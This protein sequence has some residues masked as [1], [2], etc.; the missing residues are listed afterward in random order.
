VE[1][2]EQ[3]IERIR[4]Q[5]KLTNSH[6]VAKLN[7]ADEIKPVEQEHV[8]TSNRKNFNDMKVDQF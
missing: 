8:N 1:V 7:L 3:I 2:R 4:T 6:G 5:Q